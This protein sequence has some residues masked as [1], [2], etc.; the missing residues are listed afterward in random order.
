MGRPGSS[1][2]AAGWP[3]FNPIAV[4]PSPTVPRARALTLTPCR[5][6][7]QKEDLAH[8]DV[9]LGI[10]RLLNDPRQGATPIATLVTALPVLEARVRRVYRA[11]VGWGSL[12][13]PPVREVL[14]A[15]GNHAFEAVLLE[16]L[17]D[18][19]VLRAS[20]EP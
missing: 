4:P 16:L 19:T 3:S 17:E 18:L 5:C 11:P 13:A 2:K 20:L 10:L 14:A 7:V 15:L 8:T 6:D 1:L 9:L 12:H